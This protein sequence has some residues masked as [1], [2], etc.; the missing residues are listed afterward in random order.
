MAWWQ[1]A[2][3][4]VGFVGGA[5]SLATYF[6]RLAENHQAPRVTLTVLDGD[7]WGR[8]TLQVSNPCLVPASIRSAGLAFGDRY[9]PLTMH[10]FGEPWTREVGN[11]RGTGLVLPS[12]GVCI[13][14]AE[15]SN[16]AQFASQCGAAPVDGHFEIKGYCNAT[17]PGLWRKNVRLSPQVFNVSEA[18]AKPK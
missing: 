6:S 8:Y 14:V 17:H 1:I 3:A 2:S 15:R 9:F 4:V 16:I 10:A 7:G 12:R 11:S 18:D 5:I 13:G